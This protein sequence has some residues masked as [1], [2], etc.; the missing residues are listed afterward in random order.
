MAHSFAVTIDD[1]Q[2]SHVLSVTGVRSEVDTIELKQQGP[3]GR[4]VVRLVPGR[5]KAGEFTVT[6][7]L[8][9]STTMDDWLALVR[10]GDVAGAR[11]TC[12]VALFDATGQAVKTFSLRGCWLQG[13]ELGSLTAG[14]DTPGTEVCVIRYDESVIL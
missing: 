6:R 9:D 2:L 3:D 8:S 1:V 10:L 12:T 13:I 5:P 4:F 14:A 11:K 7:L